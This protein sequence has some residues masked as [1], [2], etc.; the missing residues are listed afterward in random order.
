MHG[1]TR[2]RNKDTAPWSYNCIVVPQQPARYS[3][4]SPT[5]EQALKEIE[6]IVSQ[7][8]SGKLPLDEVVTQFKRAT[9][10]IRL[11]SKLLSEVEQQI[12]KIE[13]ELFKSSSQ[14][15]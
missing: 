14:R 8:E 12:K 11:S 2:A 7:I 1:S 9:E 13:P 10:L 4:N 6:K 15:E 5:F 3:R